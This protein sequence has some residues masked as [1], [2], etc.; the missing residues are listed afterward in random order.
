[1]TENRRTATLCVEET[2]F[3]YHSRSRD[4]APGEGVGEALG[5]A[6]SVYEA[7][8][9]VTHWRRL[10]SNFTA[11]PFELDGL[12]WRSVEHFFQAQKFR[13]VAP[14][15]YHQ[16]AEESGSELSSGDGGAVKRAG[17]R[18]GYALDGGTLAWWETVKHGEMER[19]LFARFSQQEGARRVLLLTGHAK[20][21]HKPARS[22]HTHVE[23]PLMRVRA[24]LRASGADG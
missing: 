20:L 16:F 22:K 13:D 3:M 6:A 11:S 8:S 2:V 5:E 14:V 7:L 12:T 17:G 18:R 21:T 19:A 15:Y 23:W 10:L 9:R 4:A 24:R 1:M